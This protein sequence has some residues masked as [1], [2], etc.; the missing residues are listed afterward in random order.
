M[1]LI[2]SQVALDGLGPALE[3]PPL[4]HLL[5]RGWS[6]LTWLS[7]VSLLATLHMS[8]RLW[9]QLRLA[10]TSWSERGCAALLVA[11]TSIYMLPLLG[12]NT[13]FDRY[14]LPCGI[15]ALGL[16]CMTSAGLQW[17]R[18][19]AALAGCCVLA[20]T[21]FAGAVAHDY[22]ALQR[23]RWQLLDWLV[24]EQG[25]SP[26]RIQGGF[27]FNG[28]AL[29]DAR[30]L[31]PGAKGW[32]VHDD[33]FLVGISPRPGYALMQARQIPVWLPFSPSQLQVLQR[34]PTT[35]DGGPGRSDRP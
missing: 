33:E 27:E 23:V 10:Q 6:L 14:V 11:F 20:G 28:W 3:R 32:W 30:Q 19:Y 26:R 25:I 18:S 5:W 35:Q 7:C 1:P 9:Q 8:W 13:H 22:F 24:V 15:A 4:T 21:L 17:R 12:I 16:L 34:L 31:K 2:P 29:F